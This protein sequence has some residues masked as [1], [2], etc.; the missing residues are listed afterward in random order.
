MDSVM[1]LAPE[2]ETMER[3]PLVILRTAEPTKV[4]KQERKNNWDET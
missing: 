2:E 3:N 1:L 4:V